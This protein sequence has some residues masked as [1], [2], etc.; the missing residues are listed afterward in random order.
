MFISQKGSHFFNNFFHTFTYEKCTFP[1]NCQNC[2][3]N[4][5]I[6]GRKPPSFPTFS[7]HVP[8]FDVFKSKLK[9]GGNTTKLPNETGWQLDLKDHSRTLGRVFINTYSAECWQYPK[10]SFPQQFYVKTHIF[11]LERECKF[12]QTPMILVCISDSTENIPGVLTTRKMEL[13]IKAQPG[14]ATL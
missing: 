3:P 10:D 1:S 2:P 5:H 4:T 11:N 6:S 12:M 7:T 14:F 13:V 8:H 9:K